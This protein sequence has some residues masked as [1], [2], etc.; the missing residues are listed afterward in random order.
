MRTHMV[1]KVSGLK[2]LAKNIGQRKYPAIAKFV[3]K[4]K[5]L[6]DKVI[7]N[8]T[9]E[10]QKEL[11]TMVS[12]KKQSLFR[13]KCRDGFTK[14]SWESITEE[15]QK[16]AP[17]LLKLL[18]GCIDVKRRK[19]KVKNPGKNRPK[20]DSIVGLCASIILR[21][22]SSRMNLLQRIL[23]VILYYGHASKQVNNVLGIQKQA[24]IILIISFR[25]SSGFRNCYCAC[26]IKRQ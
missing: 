26:H 2:K 9:K 19:R 24:S 11:T 16:H 18:N 10:I 6:R 14:F 17:I 1:S 15:L 23:S 22:K 21:N 25:L 20:I 3:V 12:K 7:Q 8:L 5:K 13:N 4:N